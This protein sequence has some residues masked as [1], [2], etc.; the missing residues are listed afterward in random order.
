MAHKEYSI[1]SGA[2]R[3]VFE[4]TKLLEGAGHEVIPFSMTDQRNQSSPYEKYFVSPADFS[5]PRV[6]LPLFFKNFGRMLWSREAARKM[7]QLIAD[8]KPDLVHVHN[9]Y[10]QISP[11][12]LPVIKRAGLPIVQTLHDY[13]IMCPNYLMRAG[14]RICEKC[15]YRR[16]YQPFFQK[17]V[18]SSRIASAMVG[19]EIAWHKMLGVYEKNIDV[20]I[21]PSQFLRDKMK[22]WRIK[23][24]RVEYLPNFFAQALAPPQ[25]SG[26]YILYGLARLSV[27]KGLWTLLMAAKNLPEIPF[28]FWGDGPLRPRL[29][30]FVREQ[31]MINVEFLGDPKTP[32]ASDYVKNAYAVVAPS[33]WYENNSYALIEAMAYGKPFIASNIGGNPELAGSN[34]RGLL[35]TMG[36]AGALTERIRELWTEPDLA[37]SLG[38]AGQIYVKE[39]LSGPRYLNSIQSIYRSVL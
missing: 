38:E 18:K 13:K 28:K 20:F 10:H 17:C 22:Q 2:S 35:F 27:E 6:S 36:D 26:K 1:R 7:K 4:L 19:W 11:S 24:R 16:Y 9:I 12:I 37:R 33:E 30:E 25:D 14:D 21:S 39:K 23:A 32:R 15:K 29:E 8:T 34:E 3:H 31:R 5:T